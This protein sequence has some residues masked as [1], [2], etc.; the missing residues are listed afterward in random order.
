VLLSNPT[1][2]TRLP[3]GVDSNGMT[4]IVSVHTP[5]GFVIGADGRESNPNGEI[6]SDSTCKLF[7]AEAS[8][9]RAIYAWA[10][11]VRISG[12]FC[13]FDLRTVSEWAERELRGNQYSSL[14][15]YALDVANAVFSGLTSWVANYRPPMSEV[16]DTFAKLFLVGYVDKRPE[17][18]KICVWQVFLAQLWQLTL[19]HLWQVAGQRRG[20]RCAGLRAEA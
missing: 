8:N 14:S 16:K 3:L 12:L 17:S 1:C 19:A 13:C 2:L 11:V 15:E 9:V 6:L 10:E 5:E 20:M 4:A 18:V 7:R